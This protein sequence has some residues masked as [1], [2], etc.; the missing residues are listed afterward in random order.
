[1]RQNS[2]LFFDCLSKKWVDLEKSGIPRRLVNLGKRGIRE[3]KG[4]I[5]VV[6][7]DGHYT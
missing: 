1:M 6:N 4:L 7:Y 2:Y 3:L 5:S